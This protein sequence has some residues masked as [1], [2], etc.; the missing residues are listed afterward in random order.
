[1]PTTATFQTNFSVPAGPTA[2]KSFTIDAK[3]AI[4]IKELSVVNGA[5]Q[6]RA[7]HVNYADL[8]FVYATASKATTIAT[9]NGGT[10]DVITLTP[11]EVFV[12][13]SGGAANPF[14]GGNVTAF[15]I[16]ATVSAE[17]SVVTLIVGHDG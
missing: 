4:I 6:T 3:Q 15:V 9:T 14:A 8:K 10:P 16:T 7:D 13:P 11:G 5:P 2:A 17:T 1:M 12:W